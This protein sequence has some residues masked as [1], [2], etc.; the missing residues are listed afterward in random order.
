MSGGEAISKKYVFYGGGTEIRDSNK[1][2]VWL[3]GGG[4]DR[5][6]KWF[7]KRALM[8]EKEDSSVVLLAKSYHEVMILMLKTHACQFKRFTLALHSYT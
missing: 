5:D 6:E 3:V 1:Y 4:K 7:E 8:E 2:L